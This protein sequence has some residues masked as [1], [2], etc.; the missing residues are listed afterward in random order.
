MPSHT[1][2]AIRCRE[3][4]AKQGGRSGLRFFKVFLNK[5]LKTSVKSPNFIFFSLM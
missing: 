1:M 3:V 5:N 2:V 4:S